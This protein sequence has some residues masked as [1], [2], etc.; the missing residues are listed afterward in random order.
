MS[1]RLFLLDTNILLLLLRGGPVGQAVDQR[2]RLST[3]KQR[4]FVS[5][6]THGEIHVLAQRNFWGKKRLDALEDAL[7][8]IV[9]IDIHDPQVLKSY[10]EIDLYSQRHAD[11]ARNMGKNDLWIAACAMAADLTLL[12]TDKDFA[13]LSPELLEVEVIDA[14]SPKGT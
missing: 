8:N 5:I 6:V 7:A 9:T 12:T 11:G 3:S 2:F 4:P 1:D 10:V 13:H 14:H